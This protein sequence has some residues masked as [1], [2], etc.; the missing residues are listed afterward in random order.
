M[1]AC[2]N[3][4]IGPQG[5]AKDTIAPK[6]VKEEP[7]NGIMN[8]H[9]KK[10]EIT[11]NEYIQLDKVV[12]NVLISPPQQKP[13]VVKARGKKVLLTFEEELRDSTTYTIDFGNAICDFTEKNPL[14]G[15]N[16]SFST[17]DSFDSL[18]VYGMVINAEDLNPVSGV[19]VGIHSCLADSA[20]TTIPFTRIGKSNKEGEFAIRNIHEGNYRLYGLGDV[21]R[22]YLYQTGEGLAIH[23]EV[24]TPFLEEEE[25]WDTLWHE[26]MKIDTLEWDTVSMDTVYWDPLRRDTSYIREVDTV[27]YRKDIL[28]GPAN[29]VLWYFKEKK[30]RRYFQRASREKPYSFRLVFSG[31]Q[32]EMPVF[33]A[34]ALSDS[35]ETETDWLQHA[36]WQVNTRRDTITCWLTD[37]AVILS[38]SLRLEMTYSKTDSLYNLVP[39]TDTL[40]LVYRAPKLTEKMREAQEKKERERKL[41]I[42]SN[43]KSTFEIFDTLTLYT[44][45]PL[46]SIRRDSLH[47]FQKID[48]V[49][50]PLDFVLQAKDSSHMRYQIVYPYEP[51]KMYELRVDSSAMTDIYGVSNLATKFQMKLRSKD[52]YA[53]LKILMVGYDSSMRLQLLDDKDHVLRDVAAEPA[54][55]LFENIEPKSYYLRMYFDENGD[56][57][58]TTGDWETK[59]QPEPVFYF[60]AKL[61]LRANWDFEEQF[62]YRAIP[63][64]DSK[65][66]ELIKDAAEA[67]K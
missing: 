59:R 44:D 31:E 67:K 21:S 45:F 66:Q 38:D 22:D 1:A 37:S 63:Q 8:Y 41:S 46:Q 56:G 53:T 13:P 11:F 40:M 57:S 55:T 62:D 4:G 10:I 12:E 32:T 16:F 19:V 5:G 25:R 2:A 58:W 34:L 6:V 35:V 51:E 27:V 36:L 20:L 14:S 24:L 15:Y 3:R 23:P 60:P 42:K 29:L 50:T 17:G 49:Y 64:L 65:P 48:T 33:R 52:D 61:T 26:I 7:I 39:E 18:Q 9:D 54:G 47:L 43:S 30:T 28:Y